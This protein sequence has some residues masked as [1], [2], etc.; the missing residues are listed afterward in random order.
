MHESLFQTSWVACRDR[1]PDMHVIS[2]VIP[3]DAGCSTF[4]VQNKMTSSRRSNSLR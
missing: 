4:Q 2:L 3:M 1:P